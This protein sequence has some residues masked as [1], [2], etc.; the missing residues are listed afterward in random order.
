[1][2]LKIA[3]IGN[4]H[5]VRVKTD[6][7]EEGQENAFRRFIRQVREELIPGQTAYLEVEDFQTDPITFEISQFE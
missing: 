4:D 2:N 6:F 5:V 3:L 1:M 7:S